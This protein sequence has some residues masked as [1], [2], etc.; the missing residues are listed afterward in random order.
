MS[1]LLRDVLNIPERAGAEDFVLRLT[2]SVDDAAV[3]RTLRDYVVTPALAE[4]FDSA[5][6]LVADA[7]GSGISRAAFLTGSFG[8]GKSHFMAVLY[9]ILR[10]SAPARAKTE[11]QPVIAKHDGILL[12]RK[13]LPLAF[14]F[15]GA[16]NVEK[17]LFDGYLRQITALHPGC[18]LPA[19]HE[20]ELILADAENMRQTLGDDTFFERLGGQGGG[21]GVWG[22]V[23]GAGDWTAERYGV[24]RAAAPGTAPRQE[25]VTRLVDV[26][27]RAFTH[28]A[29]YVDLDTGLRA[30]TDHAHGLGYDAVVLLVDEL[31]LWL[32]FLVRDHAAFG[33]EAQKLTKLVESA[34]GPR[35][36]PIVSFV[37]RQY[38]I[39]RWFADAGASGAEQEALDQAF[40]HQQGRFSAIQLGDDNLPFVANRRLLQPRDSAAQA[41]LDAAFSALDRRPEVW[42]VLLD[43]INTDEAHRGADEAAFRLTYP[44]SPALV[45]TLRSLAGAMQR[46]RTALKVMQQMLVERRDTLT[47]DEVIPLGDAFEHVVAG[48][49]PLDAQLAGV[50]RSATALYHNKLLPLIQA[51]H[52]VTPTTQAADEPLPQ[53]FIADDRLA[54]TLMLA[55]VAPNVPALKELTAGRLASLN[56]GSI[57]AP[58]A[59][60]EAGVVL[61]KVR[62]WALK[63]PEIHVEG[64]GQNPVIRVVIADVDY[65]SIVERA[66]G[67]DNDGRR[68][69]LLKEL[70][71]EG[72]GVTSTDPDVFGAHHQS[73]VWRGSRRE[74][75]VVFGNV[76]DAS[77]L[78]DQ[79]FQARPGTWRFVVDYPFDE[80]GHGSVE[81]LARVD[82]VRES[83]P[84]QTVVWLPRFLSDERMADLRRLVILDY[85]LGGAGERFR[86]FADHLSEADRATAR[87]ILESQRAGLRDGLRR[88][89]QEAYG[90]AAPT[91]GTLA[92][93]DSDERVLHSLDPSFQPPRPVGADLATAFRRLWDD[94]FAAVYPAHPVFEPVDTEVTI[95]ELESVAAHVERAVADPGGRVQYEGRPQL[96]RR[97]A[98]PLHVGEGGETHFLFG[99]DRFN[100]WGTEFERGF[101]RDNLAM[102]APVSV[103]TLRAWIEGLKPAWGLRPDVADLV[104]LAWAA[105][106]QRA[107]YLNGQPIAAPRPGGV[108][109]DMELRMQPLP[110]P[111]SWR[112]AV[113]RAGTIFGLSA[114]QYLTGPSVANLAELLRQAALERAADASTLVKALEAAYSTADLDE[115]ESD[116]LTTARDGLQLVN[117][118]RELREAVPAIELLAT[119]EFPATDEA[120]ARSLASAAAVSTALSGFRWDRLTPLTDAA[121]DSGEHGP[122][123]I[124]VI[125]Q[126]RAGL[127]QDEIVASLVAALTATDDAIFKWLT[128]AGPPP[129]TPPPPPPPKASG[130]AATEIGSDPAAML[131]NLNTFLA[132]HAGER[133]IV[134]WRVEDDA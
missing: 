36:I 131:E 37:A 76:R 35:A 10:H 81:D 66:R 12:G 100:P 71:R 121:G 107:W 57:V 49:E 82:R 18:S 127:R 16:E 73:V 13:I 80:P 109:P 63:V 5:L 128:S 67:E 89:V 27:F 24:A 31:V 39:R 72:L 56:H 65:Q 112:R 104:I 61:A 130:G 46:E 34:T 118:L 9:A 14:H 86:S 58:L 3:E 32:A 38:D 8:S 60:A 69:E 99:A 47:V 126:L 21:E 54:R 28:Q 25:L 115:S 48:S 55:A 101:S 95:R 97:V 77:W 74:V 33:R 133:V 20:S 11:L 113:Q 129:P 62:E 85:L 43:G 134:E 103:A 84:S 114:N 125:E 6:A 102:D 92:P 70:V 4:A 59:G 79:H 50:F 108:R 120:V 132:E 117:G 90:A 87:A 23:L 42:D 68:R 40:R 88:G 122:A 123:A 124:A 116:R 83:T 78:T 7:L 93:D 29:Q 75:D 45:T 105:L 30:I 51:M 41:V 44:F 52:G 96:V 17:A 94:A 119:S 2:D 106:K 91:P 15:L 22:S 1:T 98:N 111:E 26:F 64:L 19:L 110:R 53:A